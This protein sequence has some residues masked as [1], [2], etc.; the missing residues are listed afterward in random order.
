MKC[1]KALK[2]ASATALLVSMSLMAS[3]SSFAG[4]WKQDGR[5]WIYQY[6]DGSYHYGWLEK[7]G[8][9]YY[10][11]SS[12]HCITSQSL[13]I[14]GKSYVFDE[15]GV[16]QNN[17]WTLQ[18]GSWYYVNWQ[19]QKQTG[20][21]YIGGYWYYLDPAQDG[22]M[23]TGWQ[24]LNGKWYFLYDSGNMATGWITLGNDQY[25]LMSD[26]SMATGWVNIK[27]QSYLFNSEGKWI[28]NSD[29]GQSASTVSQTEEILYNR[30]LQ[31][32]TWNEV[33]S[34]AEDYFSSFG[35]TP[36]DC[37][38]KLNLL[39]KQEKLSDLQ[40]SAKLSKS[41]YALAIAQR[42]WKFEGQPDLDSTSTYEYET[43]L[44]LFDAQSLALDVTIVRGDTLND[45][46]NN[47]IGTQ[48]GVDAIT[49]AKATTCGVGFIKSAEKGDYI[50]VIY[51]GRTN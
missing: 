11:D 8:K 27:G 6:D 5:G 18:D 40:F 36:A 15:N 30:A 4:D 50:V 42:A 44:Q 32:M 22:K 35:S 20:W 46:L 28:P 23:L 12:G 41:A 13:M 7:G 47:A 29:S 31:D 37:I 3:F 45:A 10:L 2:K 21:Q 14:D 26:G 25:Y 39:R 16:M 38:A 9:W 49:N 1:K 33:K 17:G 51:T 34:A 48:R 43:A 24:N 19:G